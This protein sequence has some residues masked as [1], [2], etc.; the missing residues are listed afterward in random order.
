KTIAFIDYTET[1]MRWNER[2]A[3]RARELGDDETL[4]VTVANMFCWA[5]LNRDLE[6][7]RRLEPVLRDLTR[8]GTSSRAVGNAHQALSQLTYVCGRLEEACE[9]AALSV[10]VATEIG[11]EI[12]LAAAVGAEL[13]ARSAL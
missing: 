1:G 10:S 5:A 13:M 11:H 9:H 8:P 6:E 3:E 4:S 12:M 7:M 2:C